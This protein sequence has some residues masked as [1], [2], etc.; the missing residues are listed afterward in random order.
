MP[1]TEPV[2][3]ALPLPLVASRDLAVP[4]H[5]LTKGGLDALADRVPPF[6]LAWARSAGFDGKAG[7]HLMV[8][9]PDGDL[10]LVLFG[11]GGAQQEAEP[12]AFAALSAALPAGTYEIATPLGPREANAAVLGWIMGRYAFRRYKDDDG[13][14]PPLLV[15]PIGADLDQVRRT[16]EAVYLIR[17][18]VNTPASDM[19]PEDLAAAAI[20][21]AA[22]HD[23]RIAVTVGDD[24]L[25]AGYPMVHAVGR[26][27][28]RAPRLIDLN[29]GES[30]APRVTLVGKGV[31]FDTGGLDL[32]P[33][34]GMLLMKKDMGGA[35]H[36]LGLAHMIMDAQLPVR[37][38]VLIPAVENSVAGNAMRPGDVLTSRKGLTV[39]IGNTDAEGRLVLADAL[40]EADEDRPDLLVDFATLTGAARV[41]L[42][43]ELPALFTPDDELA[44]ALADHAFEQRDPLWRLPLWAP[45]DKGLESKVADLNNVSD[46]PFA[47]AITA[48][49]FLKRFV[50]ETTTWAHLDLFAWTA[51]PGPGRP[52][53]G[54]AMV[55][56]ALFA[57]IA[58][59]FPA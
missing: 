18:L 15:P 21:V 50:T 40:A 39:E 35:A 45:Y 25:E 37:L 55:V 3:L 58:E 6:A 57:L 11:I 17:D 30:D 26:A 14:A 5:C 28:D 7:S 42:G 34:A 53:G 23:A 33:S 36:A 10:G 48:A 44:A 27:S 56:R 4:I 19:G 51:K 13:K 54:E 9:G 32:K 12:Y 16:A 1:Q 43:P 2:S 20:R 47:G 31:C 46:G 29:W 38:R 59:R 52:V 49:L 8:P 24:L 41:A 22:V